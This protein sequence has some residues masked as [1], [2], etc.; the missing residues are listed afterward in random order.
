M[1]GSQLLHY[2][3]L[4]HLQSGACVI[5]VPGETEKIPEA[6]SLIYESMCGA[7]AFQVREGK[8]TF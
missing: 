2:V 3:S 8:G 6:G 1:P 7:Q 5:L 4:D